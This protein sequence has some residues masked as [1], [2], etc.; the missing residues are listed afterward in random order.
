ML[1]P[2]ERGAREVEWIRSLT[3]HTKHG[4]II[5][6]INVSTHLTNYFRMDTTDV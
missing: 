6:K 1:F 3:S 5:L 2:N 4:G